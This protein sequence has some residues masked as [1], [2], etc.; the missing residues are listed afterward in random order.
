MKYFLN[1]L[2]LFTTLSAF[3]QEPPP[4]P[5]PPVGDSEVLKVVEQM[6]RFPGCEDVEGDKARKDCAMEK[7]LKFI[8]SNI[9]YPAIAREN[10]VEGTVVIRFV[11]GKEGEILNP[12]IIR[13]I[14]ANCGLA[15]LA[16]VEKMPNWTPG[17]QDGMPVK[18]QFNLPVKFRL[19]R[20]SDGIFLMVEDMPKFPGCELTGDEN[21]DQS[22]SNSKILAYIKENLQYPEMAKKH[23]VEGE[24]HIS[25]IINELGEIINPQIQRD[26]GAGCGLEAL[27][28]V[29]EMPNW[30]PGK[31]D[32]APVKVQM[33][34]P[35]V[36]KL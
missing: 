1:I 10:G 22:C 34:L 31:K 15:A 27:R 17:M 24:C 21:Q 9:E 20:P 12:E 14:G 8:Y 33:R 6:P 4:P 3:S 2:F 7:M 19:T 30:I 29:N 16:V 35:V 25:F 13:N 18:V 23:S 36:F 5:P 11:V 32:G 26:M 28:L